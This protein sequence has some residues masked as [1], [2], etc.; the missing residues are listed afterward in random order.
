MIIQLTRFI[1]RKALSPCRVLSMVQSSPVIVETPVI[2][3]MWNGMEQ[4]S[5]N[6]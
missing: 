6:T 1:D 5:N 2:H 3:G 4:N